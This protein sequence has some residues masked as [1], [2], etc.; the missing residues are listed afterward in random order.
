MGRL[1]AL[2]PLA[3]SN[4]DSLLA[5]FDPGIFTYMPF[6]VTKGY[7]PLLDWHA[8]ENA[9]GRMITYVVRRRSD[10]ATVGSTSYLNIAP[11]HAKVEVGSTWYRKDV[12]G[13]FVNPEAKY[14]LLRNAFDK[15][16]NRVEFKTDSKNAQSRAALTKLGAKEEG[17]LRGHMWV[18]QGYF[19]D[20]VYFSVIASEWPQVR[21][22]L[23]K[24][25]AAF[26]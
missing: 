25:L 4:R 9:A 7:G 11:E 20:S 14:L 2:E 22:R 10:G 3:A 6:D 13:G 12:Q 8:A 24:R 5:A 26:D 19:R 21:A 17:T 16:W 23:E 18:P 1:I 15:G